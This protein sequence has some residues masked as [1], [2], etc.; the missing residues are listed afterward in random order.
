MIVF[1]III[2]L[3][4]F[5]GLWIFFTKQEKQI[6][7]YLKKFS[8]RYRKFQERQFY[9]SGLF[10]FFH[11]KTPPSWI[12]SLPLIFGSIILIISSW[13]FGLIA[14]DIVSRDPLT[15]VDADINKWFFYR[16]ALH[17]KNWTVE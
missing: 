13:I 3:T 12:F 9:L 2:L 17:P 6:K 14:E 8:V 15:L 10:G 11:I 16:T 7:K 1:G 5:L 4:S